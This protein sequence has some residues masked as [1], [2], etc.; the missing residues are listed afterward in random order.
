MCRLST[1]IL[2]EIDNTN[3]ELYQF[4]NDIVIDKDGNNIFED[5]TDSF[6]LYIDIAKNA[7]NG[8]PNILLQNDIFKTY[9]TKKRLFPQKEYY[10]MD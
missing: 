4:L 7:V 8:I 3:L 5:M 2:D 6:D 10:C 9:R 1:T